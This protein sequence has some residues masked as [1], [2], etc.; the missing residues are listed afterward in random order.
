M[1]VSI[2]DQTVTPD[3]VVHGGKGAGLIWM[4]Q[5]GINV[6]PAL[7]IP[8]SICVEYMKA[9]KTTMKKVAAEIK[10]VEPFFKAIFGYMPLLSVRS[11]ARSSMPG[12]MDTILNVGLDNT[13]MPVWETRL[14]TECAVDSFK[15][16]IT[17]YG[18]V[19]DSVARKDLEKDTL[20]E[21]LA[22]YER[23]VGAPFPQSKDQILN[24]IEAVFKS[25]NNARAKTY[26]KLNSIPDDWGTAVVIQ[27]MVFGNLN[28]NS[29]TGVLF[30]RNPDSGENEV[31]GEFLMNAQGE[32]VVA[33]TATPMKLSKLAEWDAEVAS[34]LISTV[35]K[36]E[37]LKGDV[38][39]V[40]FTIQDRKLFILQTRTA[41]R[42]ASAAVKIATDMVKEGVITPLQSIARVTERELD[43]ANQPVIDPKFKTPAFAVGIPACSGVVT[44]VVCL[45]SNE[46]KLV[47]A[48]GKKVI[49]VSEETTPDDIEGMVA[50]VGILTMTGGSTSHAAVVARSMNRC[51]VV[52]LG[53]DFHKHFNSGDVVSIDGGTGRVWLMEV[54]VVGGNNPL[55][56]AFRTLKVGTTELLV[57]N[58]PEMRV[59]AM[60][61]Q[62]GGIL[63][64]TNAAIESI[65]VKCRDLCTTLNLAYV[66]GESQ[67]FMTPDDIQARLQWVAGLLESLVPY[68]FVTYGFSWNE[69]SQLLVDAPNLEQLV[70]ATSHLR[71]STPSTA[72]SKAEQ[73][74]LKWLESE[75]VTVSVW[76]TADS[77]GPLAYSKVT[78]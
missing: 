16:L 13:T 51:C 73:R 14:G 75:G 20:P 4:Q 3:P 32:D 44:G 31:V 78:S 38:Q 29:G 18:N 39:D 43:L 70:L 33:G 42:S 2:F 11:G 22:V 50:A 6:P 27:A 53:A 57:S 36:L 71:V 77:T 72:W 19:V 47:A 62:L 63:H 10:H 35:T 49:L 56:S 45:T 60:C 40:E 66:P 65:V 64:L 68:K 9:P 12:M 28:E 41:K 54:P 37:Q 74:V 25:W 8:T 59:E 23:K 17:M 21:S 67:V 30:T 46:A 61:L 48:T 34:E 7:I 58:P 15:R 5:N 55:V 69:K 52:G 24:S 1:L 26:R 76:N